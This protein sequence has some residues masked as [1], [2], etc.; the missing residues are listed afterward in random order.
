[1]LDQMSGGR[2]E[3]GF[4]RG[5]SPLEI[6]IFGPDPA[7]AQEIY[8]ESLEIILMALKDHHVDYQGKFYTLKDVPVALEPKQTPHPPI[9]Y[10]IHAVDSAMRAGTNG[11]NVISLDTAADTGPMVAA[12]KVA[13]HEAG[14]VSGSDPKIGI[15]RFIVVGETDEEALAVARRAYPVWHNSFNYLF[16]HRGAAAPRHQRPAEFDA[17]A[18]L[19][20]AVAGSPETVI[21]ALRNEMTV[22][23]ANY[24]VGQFVFGD[25]SPVEAEASVGMFI[26]KVAPLLAA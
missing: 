17:M 21:E 7:D 4:G 15:G 6:D 22:S 8:T 18:A 20:R 26:D 9:W 14:H 16:N 24:L 13:Y 10:G 12:Y 2:L 1:M 5:A 25:M 3:L 19:G 23:D 11:L